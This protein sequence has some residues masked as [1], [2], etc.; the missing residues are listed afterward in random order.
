[1]S[2]RLLAASVCTVALA[3]T[4][5]R[6]DPE[7]FDRAH[8]LIDQLVDSKSGVMVVAHRGC[9]SEAPENSLPAIEACVALGVDIV[10]LDVRETS[11]G[12]LV[13]M[14]DATVDRTTTGSGPV[15]GMTSDALRNLRLR[16]GG[17][18]AQAQAS[19]QRVPTL[20]EALETARGR[21]L[22]NVDDKVGVYDR[23]VA[24]AGNMGMLDHL[25]LKRETPFSRDEYRRMKIGDGVHFMPKITQGGRAL[26][27][28]ASEYRWTTPVAFELKFAD[29]H[30]L[31]EGADAIRGMHA[32]IWVSTLSDSPAKSA[33]HTDALALRNPELHWGRLIELGATMI[34]TDSPAM[35][36]AFLETHGMRHQAPQS[37]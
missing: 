11:D 2:L 16:A 8:L 31:V 20:E 17:G 18:G 37:H 1:M 27:T 6:I 15:A 12:R 36:I 24:L 5:D 28:V 9:W 3:C 10:E 29:E 35:L 19:A 7:Q 33:G 26:S 13:L 4:S 21:V 32:R 25:I 22:I 34:Q 23:V 30:F 14:H